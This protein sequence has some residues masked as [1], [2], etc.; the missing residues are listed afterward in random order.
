MQKLLAIVFML[1]FTTSAF[2]SEV[3]KENPYK[4]IEEAAQITFD[5]FAREEAEIKKNP[6]ILKDIVR[7]ELMPYVSYKYAGLKVLGNYR[8]KASRDEILE[9]LEAFN[10]YLITSYAQVFTLYEQQE[11]I[12]EPAKPI[13]KE[14]ILLVGVDIMNGDGPPINIKFKVRKFAQKDEQGKVSHY[15]WLAFDL[16]AEG[17]S[18]LDAKQKELRSIL[19]QN[20]VPKVTQMLKEKSE[21][22]IVF[23]NDEDVKAKIQE[24][25]TGE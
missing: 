17:I 5:R 20:G 11:V 19:A 10:S 24:Q 13:D 16:V 15:D 23:K 22:K 6:E 21:R 2:A 7:E 1:S 25:G 12:F 18:L 14:K 9:F 3:S 4:M 8:K